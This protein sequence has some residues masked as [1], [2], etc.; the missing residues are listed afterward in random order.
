MR[1]TLIVMVKEPRPG[2]VKTRLAAGIGTVAA[3]RWYRGQTS[4]LLH[5]LRD[6]RWDIVLSVAP[7][8]AMGSRVWPADL[9]RL[10]QGRGHLGRRMLGAMGAVRG[11]VLLI[12]SDIPGVR[13]AH[14]A[15]GFAALGPARIVLGPA[16][17]GGF[18]MIGRAAGLHLPLGA[19][20]G[21]DWSTPRALSQTALALSRWRGTLVD[22]LADVDSAADLARL[23]RDARRAP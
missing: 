15:R 8:R 12:G 10:A 1:G 16:C 3:A 21:V 7:D 2:A 23:S 6:P 9:P 11:P 17:D 18:W 20:D 14:V 5:R 22:R 19:L 13:R 4:A